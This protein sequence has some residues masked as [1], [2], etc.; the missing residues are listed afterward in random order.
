VPTVT[1][2]IPTLNR[3]HLLRTAARSALDQTFTDIE[4]LISDDCSDDATV[5]VAQEFGD[6]RVR[7]VRTPVRLNMPDSFEFALQQAR[8]T[9]V[10][11]LTDDSYLLPECVQTALNAAEAH[12]T[13]MVAWRHAGYFDASWI[14]PFRRNTLYVPKS[15]RN[16]SRLDSQES[17]RRWF[18][19]VIRHTTTM[20]RSINSLCHRDVI[21]RALTHQPRLF[22]P[23][24]PDHSSGVAMLMNTDAYAYL[25]EP[26]V[27]DGVTKESIGPSQSFTMGEHAS[28]FYDS[29]GEEM[30]R[31]TYLGLPTV[32]AIVAQSFRN[33]CRY[34]S[35][36]PP[37]DERNLARHLIDSLAKIEV[38]ARPMDEY[39]EVLSNARH[40][41]GVTSVDVATLRLYSRIK[42]SA[43]KLVRSNRFLHR[44]EALRGLTVVPGERFAFSDVQG[45]AKA[46]QRLR[47]ALTV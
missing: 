17:L 5:Q 42:W 22:L 31:V 45:A 1:I 37:L 6:P 2:A 14:E 11:F 4:V 16:I 41:I 47:P 20:P 3:S 46:L 13:E 26:L 33:A 35:S 15:S 38:Y 44:L 27:V 18:R 12:G 21:A 30:D 23:P 8:G 7:Y 36:C 39:F 43:V 34:Y 29:F 28:Q 24:A 9:Y 19:D 10:T 40:R 32:P 25:D